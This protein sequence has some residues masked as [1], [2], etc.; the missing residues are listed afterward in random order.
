[1]ATKAV[2]PCTGQHPLQEL[3]ERAMRQGHQVWVA[4]ITGSTS[5][6][7]CCPMIAC[8]KCG[9]WTFG[10]KHARGLKLLG[11][12]QPPTTVGKT[13]WRRL[14]QGKHP[15]ADAA[16]KRCQV[17]GLGPWPGDQAD[18]EADDEKN[19]IDIGEWT[20]APASTTPHTPGANLA[21]ATS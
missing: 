14:T 4:A 12:C 17:T 9:G 19:F 18:D 20:P 11:P 6:D 21:D 1:M 7:V 2:G 15:K 16:Y 8:R 3:K 10:S 5:A 13:A